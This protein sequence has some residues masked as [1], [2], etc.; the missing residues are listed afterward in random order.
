[1]MFPPVIEFRFALARMYSAQ[2]HGVRAVEVLRELLA[3][4]PGHAEAQAI[5]ETLRGR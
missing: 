2:R 4:A 5:L 1:M 3:L